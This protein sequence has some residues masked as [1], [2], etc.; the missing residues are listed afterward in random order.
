[1]DPLVRGALAVSLFSLLTRVGE[2][3]RRGEANPA[4]RTRA[5]SEARNVELSAPCPRGTLPD[6][7]VCV[8]VP[9]TNAVGQALV[10]EQNEH[11]DRHGQRR[12]YDQI[13]LQEGRPKDYRRYRLPVP[14]LADQSFVESG[15]DLDRPDAEQRRGAELSAVGHGGVDLAQARGT[16]VR[17][18]NLENQVGQA[19]V[20]GQGQLFGNSVVTRHTLRESGTLRDYLV[21]YGHLQSA[22]PGLAHGQSL[23]AGALIGYVGDS[24]SPGVVHLHLEVRRAREGV[25]AGQLPLGQVNQNAKTVVCDPRN[26]LQLLR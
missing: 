12:V 19:E 26:V 17:L 16:E 7:E 13:P 21:I 25:N 11:H 22:A 3:R 23:E 1:M 10:A 4:Q 24:G 9:D 14:V 5:A 20:V 15:Y 6:G 8:P 2:P 18:V